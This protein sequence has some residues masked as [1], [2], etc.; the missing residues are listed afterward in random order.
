MEIQLYHLKV[1]DRFKL[2]KEDTAYYRA[3]WTVQKQK[4]TTTEV[5]S[6]KQQLTM[7][8]DIIVNKIKLLVI[9]RPPVKIQGQSK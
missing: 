5:I 2:R 9:T 3:M 6:G 8:N 1:G 4:Q 7:A